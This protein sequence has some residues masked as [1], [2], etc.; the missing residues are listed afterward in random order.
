M[1]V[2]GIQQCESA[3]VYISP[4]SGASLPPHHSTPPLQLITEHQV[5]LPVLYSSFP[6]AVSHMV[7][8]IFNATLSV[9]SALSFSHCVC[10]SI[11]SVCVSSLALQVCSSISSLLIPWLCFNIQ[12]LVFS[13]WLTSCCTT[14]CRF[15]YLSSTDSN[16]FLFMTE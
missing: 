8:Y 16:L 12:Y 10:K 1:L 4:P 5:E 13:F 11:L 14:S 3:S 7:M 9:C 6:L 2:Y 15:V